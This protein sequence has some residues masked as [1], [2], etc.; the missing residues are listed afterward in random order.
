MNRYVVIGV[1]FG[2]F[3]EWFSLWELSAVSN[4]NIDFLIFT[5]NKIEAHKNIRYVDFSMSKFNGL[6]SEKLGFNVELNS[7]YKL[8]DFKVVYGKIF[9]DYI[10][11]YDF[12]AHTDFDMFYGDLNYFLSKYDCKIYDR[13]LP[14]GH[15]AFYRNSSEVV[16]RYAEYNCDPNYIQILQSPQS[17]AFDEVGMVN[18]Y[19]NKGYPFFSGRIFAEINQRFKRFK[20]N[21]D[22]INYIYQ[23]FYY[24]RGKIYRSYYLNGEIKQNEFMYIHFQS[25]RLKVHGQVGNSFYITSSGIYRKDYKSVTL[26]DIKRFNKYRGRLYEIL[27]LKTFKLRCKLKRGLKKLYK[28]FGNGKSA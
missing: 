11:G 5:D 8:C 6:S 28:I 22:D 1:Y 19:T 9:E 20:L 21:R 24:E 16:N 18:L 26:K 7:A 4:P 3:P 15:L 17:F 23:I 13:F 25:R 14:L 10:S 27:E 12:W 2:T